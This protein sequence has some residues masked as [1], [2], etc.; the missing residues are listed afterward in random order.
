MLN[1]A[2]VSGSSNVEARAKTVYNK[3]AG[4]L[5]FTNTRVVWVPDGQ[6]KPTLN[7]AHSKIS[8]LFCTKEGVPKKKLKL[9]VTDSDEAYMF[10]FTSPPA[11]AEAELAKFKSLLLEVITQ[12]TTKASIPIPNVT[13]KASTPSSPSTPIPRPTTPAYSRASSAT[14]LRN[15][16]FSFEIRQKVLTTSPE[17][18]SLHRELVETGQITEEEFWEGR[19]HL[20]AT[21]IAASQQRKGK[22]SQIVAPRLKTG[23]QGQIMLTLTPQLLADIFEEF[24]VVQQAYA[25]NV[26]KPLGEAEFWERY[27]SSKLFDRHRASSRNSV[28]KPDPIFDKY[29]EKEDDDTEP[30]HPRN[31]RVPLFLDLEATQGDHA[32]TGN[33][34]DVTMQA[35][36]RK[37]AIPIIRR[38]N[39]HSERLLE[40]ALG[41]KVTKHGDDAPE[42]YA[43]ESSNYDSQVILDDLRG[44]HRPQGLPLQVSNAQTLLNDVGRGQAVVSSAVS[45]LSP[46]EFDDIVSTMS[47]SLD[48]WSTELEQFSIK[49]DAANAAV[50]DMMTNVMSRADR[51]QSDAIPPLILQQMRSCATAANE[52]LRQYWSTIHPPSSETGTT[53][54][55]FSS[56]T[57]AQKVAR[58]SKMITYLAK[59]HDKAR[60]II[61]SGQRQGV[62]VATMEAAFAPLL[63]AVDKAL[64]SYE[65]ERR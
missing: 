5:T 14:P 58:Q 21:E 29:L 12:N 6:S 25:E 35:G 9:N 63:V 31:E 27:F 28:A 44:S 56:A 61:E 42:H 65:A 50:Q 41:T 62:S 34:K 48:N 15:Q 38:F 19:E 57:P 43:A 24:P 17:L 1:V 40:S 30:L 22:S 4:I 3:K 16:P 7:I 26:P 60:A 10:H 59:T 33:E 53:L 46:M 54:A 51:T 23:E 49:P 52:F 20:L 8:N 11:V 36:K 45:K 55:A 32:E 64:A 39:E 13:G 47:S 18:S 2:A 37:N